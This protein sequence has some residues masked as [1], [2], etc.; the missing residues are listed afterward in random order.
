MKDTVAREEAQ[1]KEQAAATQLIKDDAQKDLDAALP[2]LNA[3][4]SAL[5]SL[6]KNDITEIKSFSKPPPLVLVTMEGVCILFGQ[7]P[8]WDTSKKVSLYVPYIIPNVTP[9]FQHF[10]GSTLSSKL[11]ALDH[12]Y[13]KSTIS[14]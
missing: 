13:V 12:Q 2:A 9:K 7:K 5:N 6:N 14:P 4:V 1:V 8:D 11:R 10:L 3:A